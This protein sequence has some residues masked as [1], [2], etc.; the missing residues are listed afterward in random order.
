ML[1][2][3]AYLHLTLAHD[4]DLSQGH[5]HFNCE[6]LVNGYKKAKHYYC[7]QVEKVY[8]IF[9]VIYLHLILANFKDQGQVYEHIDCEYIW[10]GAN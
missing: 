6:Y 5:A 1:F 8:T 7:C 9:T 3:M 4:K 10:S 2:P